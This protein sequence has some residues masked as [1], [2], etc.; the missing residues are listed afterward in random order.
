[1]I[2]LY[3]GLCFINPVVVACSHQD[4]NTQVLCCLDEGFDYA[5][6]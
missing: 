3:L 2:K 4:M 6:F 1:M 5:E